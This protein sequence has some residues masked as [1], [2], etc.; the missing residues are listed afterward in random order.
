MC[1]STYEVPRNR[2]VQRQNS[3]GYQGL[4][5]LRGE[6]EFLPNKHRVSVWDD[7]NVW[8][9][10]RWSLYNTADLLDVAELCPYWRLQNVVA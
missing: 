2:P 6:W 1:N 3:G 5:V 10:W 7:E 8:K 9:W 4:W